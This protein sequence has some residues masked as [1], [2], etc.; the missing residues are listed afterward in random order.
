LLDRQTDFVQYNLLLLRMRGSGT[1]RGAVDPTATL[2]EQAKV[3]A[4]WAGA[5]PGQPGTGYVFLEP[6]DFIR[7]REVSVSLNV[8]DHWAR[9][10]RLRNAMLTVSGRNLALWAPDY[11]GDPESARFRGYFG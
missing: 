8:P 11:T 3:M 2:S 10:A 4:S 7:L 6:G 5:A 1:L 9:A